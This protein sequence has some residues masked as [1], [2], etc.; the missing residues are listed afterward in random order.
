MTTKRAVLVT[1]CSSG[2]GLATAKR[3]SQNGAF[4]VWA[5]ARDV[6]SLAPLD[7]AGCRVAALDVE[8][9]DTMPP[10]IEAIEKEHGG[11]WALVNNA[12]Y[13]QSGALET[14]P[15]AK[16]RKQFETNVFGLVRL[17]QLVLPGMRRLGGGRVVNVSSMGGTLTFPGGGAYHASKYAVEALSDALRFECEPSNIQVVVIQPGTIRTGFAEAVAKEI[18]KADAGDRFGPFNTRIVQATKEA[19][20]KGPLKALGGEPDDVARVIE[21]ALTVRRPKTRYPVTASAR[22]LMWQRS[23]MSD[24]MWDA[25]LRSQF[26][27]V[28][29]LLPASTT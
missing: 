27:E 13:S 17:T 28:R 15:V 22:L 12:G 4:A 6:K 21:K 11:V 10:V 23:M 19:Y 26:G 25:F 18:P 3:L 16:L 20:E 24:R 9:E 5:T 7:Q 8:R 14:L 29:Q 2:I 1:G